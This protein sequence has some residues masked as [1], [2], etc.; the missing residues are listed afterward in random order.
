MNEY[1]NQIN[2]QNIVNITSLQFN[3]IPLSKNNTINNYS[4]KR[5]DKNTM[6]SIKTNYLGKEEKE[7]IIKRAE[8]V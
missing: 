6:P 1:N 3:A 4:Q 7:G 5:S 8:R 2:I